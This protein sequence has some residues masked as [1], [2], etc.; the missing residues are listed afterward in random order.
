MA[1]LWRFTPNQSFLAKKFGR[2]WALLGLKMVFR[3]D[4]MIFWK[5]IYPPMMITACGIRY[6]KEESH[7]GAVI[8][9][10]GELGLAWAW[11]PF[12]MPYLDFS[13]RLSSH[14]CNLFILRRISELRAPSP[15]KFISTRTSGWSS[16]ASL[17]WTRQ[18]IMKTE[19]DG[20]LGKDIS[21]QMI[22]VYN[23]PIF[24]GLSHGVHRIQ[25]FLQENERKQTDPTRGIHFDFDWFLPWFNW[26]LNKLYW[27][28]SFHWQWTVVKSL[29][30]EEDVLMEHSFWSY[31][32]KVN[33]RLEYQPKILVLFHFT[34]DLPVPPLKCKNFQ[35]FLLSFKPAVYYVFF[36]LVQEIR[37]GVKQKV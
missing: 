15:V 36:W 17:T 24:V 18:L 34:L 11:S 25:N 6:G 13:A 28:T 10:V 5:I 37:T 26:T 12:L 7:C 4:M 9:S 22:K 2:F 27:T 3:K 20:N 1:E 21:G 23:K 31:P 35:S 29:A 32:I 33:V 30:S 16:S 19:R 14:S 8:S